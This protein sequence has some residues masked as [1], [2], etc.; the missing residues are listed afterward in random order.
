MF[1]RNC[2]FHTV[3][4]KGETKNDQ[5][6]YSKPCFEICQTFLQ[7]AETQ[8]RFLTMHKSQIPA[9]Q[10]VSLYWHVLHKR[11]D[12]LTAYQDGYLKQF[13]ETD[14]VDLRNT[15]YHIG[16]ER[17][18]HRVFLPYASYMTPGELNETYR[19]VWSGH[20]HSSGCYV[21]IPNNQLSHSRHNRS[22]TA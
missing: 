15:Y 2:Y 6:W 14:V 21:A 5:S 10:S 16:E 4:E 1:I 9:L 12:L 22:E 7:F 19:Y 17:R 3:H 18:R 13:Q 8:L 11:V 20:I